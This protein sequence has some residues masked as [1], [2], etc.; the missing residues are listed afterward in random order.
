MAEQK[1]VILEDT[2]S[3]VL[4]H[5]ERALSEGWIT[6]YYQPVVRS[7]TGML[8]GVE[9]LCR[10]MDP[11]Y[12]MLSPVQ[13]IPVLENS[14]KIFALDLYVLECVCGHFHSRIEGRQPIVPVSVN[15]SRK[16]FLHPDLV[17][18]I[19][20]IASLYQVPREL[21]NIEI[22]ESAFIQQ[23]DL[24]SSIVAQFHSLGYQV[25]MDDFGTAYS[26]LG[27][28][29]D[30]SFD[31]LKIDMSFLSN[32]SEKARI[33]IADVVR[34]A[35][36]I[37]IQTLAEGVETKDQYDFLRGIGCEKIQGYYFG[38]PMKDDALEKHCNQKHLIAEPLCWKEY[39]DAL[40]RIDY[41]TDDT[42]CVVEDDGTW[43][44]VLFANARF[45]KA[46]KKTGL[47]DL[48]KCFA[49]IN[50]PGNPAHDFYRNFANEYLRKLSGTQTAS[51]PSGNY[52]LQLSASVVSH[53]ESHMICTVK[54]RWIDLQ[55]KTIYQKNSD[56]LDNLYFL[57]DEIAVF[58][59]CSHSIYVLKSSFS[60]RA[61]QPGSV[62]Q[63]AGTA[64]HSMIHDEVYFADQDRAGKFLNLDTLAKRA[65][66]AGGRPLCT[67]LRF[68]GT[69]G[70][71][72]WKEILF[73]V[74][75]SEKE[76]LLLCVVLPAGMDEAVI[77][78]VAQE[79]LKGGNSDKAL[80]NAAEEEIAPSV[81][82]HNQELNSA[83]KYFW[84][85]RQRR[86]VGA[87]RSF[88]DYYG[89]A[90][91]DEIIGRTDEDM[92]WHVQKEPFRDDEL[93]VI[94]HG[95]RVY[96]KIGTCIARGVQHTIVASKIP[97]YRDGRIIGLMGKF[98]DQ[99]EILQMAGI[100]D[101]IEMV[102][103][104]TKLANTTGFLYSFRLYLQQLWEHGDSLILMHIF[105]PEY[106]FFQVTYGRKAGDCCL[107]AFAGVLTDVL[108]WDNVVG[109]ISG[110]HF[111]VLLQNKKEKEAECLADQ[112]R[113]RIRNLRHIETWKFAGTAEIS[114]NRICK[115]SFGRD[116]FASA[117]Y[118]MLQ[119]LGSDN[120]R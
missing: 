61:L 117:V 85:D 39:Y 48:E 74:I 94:E 46:L 35:K 20:H 75:P 40:G 68:L 31:E 5:F 119:N 99:D 81:L 18:R 2:A 104:V 12:G 96:R 52:Y 116:D 32:S 71:F 63:D 89:F 88:L 108:G 26:S 72:V 3:Y 57:C 17:E 29:K 77:Q 22:T 93:D 110:A 37:G 11:Q 62:L 105:I 65:R 13:F 70:Q 79:A 16:D 24:I 66:D 107:R 80:Q 8:C 112:V 41:Q 95:R 101:Q 45:R 120:S 36:R 100:L 42:L 118:D 91:V 34:M 14:G 19:E 115:K 38:R 44:R 73:I 1:N 21:L 83:D 84:K 49:D 10:W 6:V 82:W 64:I 113:S 58:H 15:L 97:I 28:L 86:F 98:T 30:L 76:Q 7:M 55:E 43:F 9:A 111:F 109:R 92:H 50:A 90:S 27:A 102:D 78:Q 51:F 59:L 56:Y 87:S 103:P 25:W 60:D 33:I 23:Q 67:Q 53:F 4:S 54:I 47:K 106:Q 114:F 69:D